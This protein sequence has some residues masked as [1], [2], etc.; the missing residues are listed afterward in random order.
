VGCP[1]SLFLWGWNSVMY[2]LLLFFSASLLLIYLFLFILL[3]N[4][5]INNLFLSFFW[6]I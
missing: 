4:C 5:F 2:F 1:S 3:L 6:F